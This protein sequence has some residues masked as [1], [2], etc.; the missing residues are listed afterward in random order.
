MKVYQ[1]ESGQIGRWFQKI[2]PHCKE[3][4]ASTYLE[5]FT[6]GQG[7]R[8]RSEDG[9]GRG[10]RVELLEQL[11]LE[12]KVLNDGFDDKVWKRSIKF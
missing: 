10:Q 5:N 6:D 2:G 3:Q 9:L 11:L 8:V 12:A 4:Q 1:K 7:G